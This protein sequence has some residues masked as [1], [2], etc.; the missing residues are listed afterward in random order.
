MDTS[1]M[2]TW[3]D[4]RDCKITDVKNSFG[5]YLRVSVD[6]DIIVTNNEHKAARLTAYKGE[7]FE[8]TAKEEEVLTFY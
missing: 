6:E 2:F 7:C 8:T 5:K 1:L 4:N 3:G